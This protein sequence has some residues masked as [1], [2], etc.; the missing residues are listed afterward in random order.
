MVVLAPSRWMR[1]LVAML[2][3]TSL[4]GT[5]SWADETGNSTRFADRLKKIKAS[6]PTGG[7]AAGTIKPP[8]NPHYNKIL[9]SV[10]LILCEAEDGSTCNGTGWVLDAKQRLLVTN[11]HVIEGVSE[12]KVFFPEFV[13][14]QLVT[15]PA[16]SIVPGRAVAGRVVDSD[17]T[18]D[19][20][21]V[22]IEKLSP[23]NPEL[24]LAEASATPGQNIHSIAGSAVGSQSLWIYSTGHVRQIV[25]GILASGYEA[26]V[27]ESDMAT[28]Q[29]NSGGPVVDDEGRVVAVVEGARTDARLVSLKVELQSLAAYLA[30][31]LRCV[32]PQSPEDLKFAAE[33][34]LN[35]ERLEVALRLVTTA[36][37][38]DK[39]NADLFALRG[40][41]WISQGDIDSARG[42]FEEALEIDDNCAE[43]HCGQGLIAFLDGEFEEAV[44]QYSHALRNDS[45]NV[46][47]LLCR[48][49]A[50]GCLGEADKARR[51]FQAVLKKVPN[52]PPA[53]KGLAIVDV[54]S[55]DYEAGLNGL[56]AVVDFLPEDPDVYYY[57]GYALN[58]VS[59]FSDA[60]TIL[61]HVLELDAE[62]P[63]GHQQL[64]NSLVGQGKFDEAVEVLTVAVEADEEDAES[65]LLL[66]T[67]VLK[68]GDRQKGTA[69]IRK[70]MGLTDDEDLKATA[71]EVLSDAR[72]QR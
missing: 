21:I 58:S 56:S 72:N 18:C 49:E 48:G 68:L 42:D 27:L 7:N 6:A 28:N 52:S 13:D 34:H 53:L 62:Y 22:Q 30:L 39:R 1:S 41:C 24:E 5:S 17:P 19:L 61:R 12:C 67:A 60:E 65:Y 32:D 10:A 69:L 59:N 36:L 9:R 51:D 16:R 45:D 54:E 14:G 70:A 50:N 11:H 57:S 38:Q 35:A 47:Y 40:K 43:A 44:A 23:D 3:V 20:A 33:R 71:R 26:D 66:G 8:S 55:G 31:G 29:G 64:G 46:D 37:K 15:D 63:Y 4:A 25:R 2:V